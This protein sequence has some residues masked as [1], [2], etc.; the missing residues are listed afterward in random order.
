MTFSIIT[1]TFN[2]AQALPRTLASVER[3]DFTGIEHLIIDG[4][5]T[6]D[7][8]DIATAYKERIEKR[9]TDNIYKVEISSE[10]DKGIYDAMNKGLQRATGDYVIFLNAGDC[11]HDSHQLSL[12]AQMVEETGESKW[13]AVI[14]GD[15]D[16]IDNDGYYIGKRQHTPPEHLTWKSF[17]QGMLVCHQS[18]YTLR[19]LAQQIPFD[20]HYRHSADVDWCIR[21]MKQAEAEGRE[22]LN[23]HLTLADYQQEGNTTR[24]HRDSLWERFDVMSRHYGKATTIAMHIWFVFRGAW[25]KIFGGRKG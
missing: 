1:I 6:D 25:R 7:T 18:F 14:Y 8:V 16:L 22:L 9:A 15:T 17:K 23:S 4:A 19:S 24:N 3:Q 12:C 2:A 13:P 11:L 20:L 10:P 5:S 21:V